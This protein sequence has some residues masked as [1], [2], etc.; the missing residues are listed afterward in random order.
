MQDRYTRNFIYL[1]EETQTSLKDFRIVFGGVGLGSVIAESALRLGFERFLLIDG[2]TVEESNLNRQNYTLTD[3]DKTKVEAIRDRL[4][5]INPNAQVET[6]AG[7]LTPDNLGDFLQPGDLAINALDFDT[8]APFAFDAHCKKLGIP[9]V[10]P[11]NFGWATAA[12]VVTPESEDVASLYGPEA[13][14]EFPLI[15][16]ML[17]KLE[18]MGVG[19]VTGL[20]QL[21]QEYP[22]YLPASPPQLTVGATLAA[23][24]TTSLLFQL[25]TG[26]QV[27]TFPKPYYLSTETMV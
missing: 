24:L 23:G 10:H 9:V 4:L 19:P 22:K 18:K 3:V 7:Y 20:K 12:Y 16:D 27:D 17:L 14:F 5:A 11:F 2:D 8:D 6:F 25:A 21:R 1:N 15:D 26:Q 13:R